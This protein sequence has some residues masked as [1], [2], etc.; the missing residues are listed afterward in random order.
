MHRAGVDD[1]VRLEDSRIALQRHA[2]RA[3]TA[4][5]VA[6]HAFAHRAEVFL[7]WLTRLRR[8]NSDRV[9]VVATTA[10]GICGRITLSVSFHPLTVRRS[11]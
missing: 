10:A 9:L 4:W 6:F 1:L 5:G 8:R 11:R 2:A 7:A 3:T